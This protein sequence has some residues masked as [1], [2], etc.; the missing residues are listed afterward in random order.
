MCGPAIKTIAE[1]G[2]PCTKGLLGKMMDME[3]LDTE[4]RS[5]GDVALICM[6]RGL[7]SAI[8]SSNAGNANGQERGKQSMEL[9]LVGRWGVLGITCWRVTMYVSFAV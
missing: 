4:S 5:C 2:C 6:L 9:R 1:S 7:S 3:I 8:A